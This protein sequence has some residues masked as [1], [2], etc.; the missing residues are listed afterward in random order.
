MK[1]ALYAR[2]S[3]KDQNPESQLRELREYAA[4][5]GWG[6]QEFVDH[7]VSGTRDSR[8]ALDEMLTAVRKGSV[9]VVLCWRFDRVAR[10]TRFLVNML[11]ELRDLGVA[12]VSLQEQIDTA[13]PM[14]K[15]MF[16][17]IAAL[18]AFERDMI[19]E[20]VRSGIRRAKAEG[21]HVGRPIGRMLKKPVY[22][23][24]GR[25]VSP[26]EY[27][28]LSGLEV[29]AALRKGGSTRKAAEVLGVSERTVRRLKR[30]HAGLVR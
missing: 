24:H 19:V 12:F 30:E 27:R 13:S 8:P 1:C 16:T 22:D 23:K 20:R 7:G 3:T 25:K 18:A 9:D 10:S 21:K 15:A 2:V 29:A 11:D 17:I 14:G 26:G 6:V 28:A 4:R 5:R